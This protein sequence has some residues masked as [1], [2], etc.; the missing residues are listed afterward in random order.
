M[1]TVSGLPSK[2]ALGGPEESTISFPAVVA[3]VPP[4]RSAVP[5]FCRA[6]SDPVSTEHRLTGGNI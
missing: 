6:I 5:P 1:V 2:A 4:A 3:S